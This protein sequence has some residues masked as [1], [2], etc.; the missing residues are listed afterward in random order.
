MSSVIT[1]I[2]EV[3]ER[4]IHTPEERAAFNKWAQELQ[5]SILY[6]EPDLKY[7]MDYDLSL[8]HI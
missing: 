7:N 5:V 8:I 2:K 3:K 4:P 6:V 1:P